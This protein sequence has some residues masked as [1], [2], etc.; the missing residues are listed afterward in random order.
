MK[1]APMPWIL[2][3]AGASGWPASVWVMSGEASGSTA[4]VRI[5]LRFV[6]LM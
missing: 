1:F 6:F 3:G 2:C 4:T 5:G